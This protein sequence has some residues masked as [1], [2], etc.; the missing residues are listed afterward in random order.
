VEEFEAA[1]DQY[2]GALVVVSHDRR[3]L[4]RWRGNVLELKE[5][6]VAYH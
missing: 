6:T 3:F 2:D 1:L 5:N 4:S